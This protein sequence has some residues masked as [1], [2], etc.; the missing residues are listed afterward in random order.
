MILSIDSGKRKIAQIKGGKYNNKIL[1]IYDPNDYKNNKFSQLEDESDMRIQKVKPIYYD[2]PEDLVSD[3]L[4]L[5]ELGVDTEYGQRYLNLDKVRKALKKGSKRGLRKP[6][7]SAYNLGQ[8]KINNKIQKEVKLID[9]HFIPLPQLFESGSERGYVAGSSGSGKSTYIGKYIGLYK[10]MFPKRNIWVFS[11]LTEDKELDKHDVNR[12]LLDKGIVENPIDP[13]E[14]SNGNGALC[15]FDDI[16][17]IADKKI[18]EAVH[19]LRDDLLETGRHQK[20]STISTGH[21]LMDYKKTRTLL[22]EA[23]FV[24]FFPQSGSSYHIR[25]F[26]KIYCGL[27]NKNIEK[28]MAL[29]SRWVTIYKVY[30]MYVISEKNCY[31]IN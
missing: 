10:Q 20:I 7:I 9:G 29:P 25:R 15:I 21:Q 19:K 17:T 5:N 26:L 2:Y 23:S 12:I 3:D 4:L 11:R 18:N 6:L 13:E 14:L 22:N 30:P 16:D 28:I 27:D 24:T 8:E 1:K 31:L